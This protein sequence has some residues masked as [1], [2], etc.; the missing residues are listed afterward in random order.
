MKTTHTLRIDGEL[1]IFRSMELKPA[2]LPIPSWCVR[3][4]QAGA[5]C[6]GIRYLIYSL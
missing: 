5:R 1:T 3:T 2:M 4:S 6:I